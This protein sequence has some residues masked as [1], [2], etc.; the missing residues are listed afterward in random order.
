[1]SKSKGNVIAPQEVMKNYSADALRFWAAGSKLGE[2]L[3]YQEK[4]LVTGKK[5]VTKLFNATR[6]VFMNLGDYKGNLAK[7]KKFE[8]IDRKDMILTQIKVGR[9][10][11]WTR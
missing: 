9:L 3:D 7:P 1:M 11:E 6:F 5:F 8:K 2:D 4:D 10:S